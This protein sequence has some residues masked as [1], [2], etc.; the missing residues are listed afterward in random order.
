MCTTPDIIISMQVVLILRF[1]VQT[2]LDYAT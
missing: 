1:R 2:P